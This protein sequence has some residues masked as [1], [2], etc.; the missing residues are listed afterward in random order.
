M[1]NTIYEISLVFKNTSLV[2]ADIFWL[3]LSN[4]GIARER[5][6]QEEIGDTVKLAFYETSKEKAIALK[7]KF[8]QFAFKKVSFAVK[9]LDE[10]QWLTKWKQTT[11]PFYITKDIRVAILDKK[12]KNMKATTKTIIIDTVAV[13][14][15]GLHPTTKL[16][17]EFISQLR[18]KFISF[19]DIGTGTGILSNI[20]RKYG[21][22]DVWGID[23]NKEAVIR[24]KANMHRNGSQYDY[25]KAVNFS[26]FS[27]KRQFD[28]IAAN[29]ITDDLINMRDKI[30]SYVRPGKYLA[31]SGISLANYPK[32]VKN[33][34]KANLRLLKVKKERGWVAALYKKYKITLD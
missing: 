12:N 29:L 20:A 16:M 8:T 34:S 19:F 9:R 7:E 1:K 27:H 11:R 23:I 2:K 26:N 32:F 13:F 6:A 15:T 28:F 21:A 30:I 3:A 10:S 5:I 24:A 22:N 33:F 17:A 25:V 31:V 18:G 4:L 14:G